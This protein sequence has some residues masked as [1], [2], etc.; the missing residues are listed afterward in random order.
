MK[1]KSYGADLDCPT[2]NEEHIC[3][4]SVSEFYDAKVT[5]LE[6]PISP[7]SDKFVYSLE[8]SKMVFLIMF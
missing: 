1:M 5:I 3:T 7:G 8:K 2:S 6:T 4:G